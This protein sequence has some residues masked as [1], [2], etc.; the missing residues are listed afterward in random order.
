MLHSDAVSLGD[1][2][3]LMLGLA[4]EGPATPGFANRL[5]FSLD[6][7]QESAAGVGENGF[8]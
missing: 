6:D 1:S 5:S 7:W 8:L 3:E 4:Q 2:Q